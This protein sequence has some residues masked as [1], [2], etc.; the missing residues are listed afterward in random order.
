MSSARSNRR[1]RRS[2][3]RLGVSGSKSRTSATS[4]GRF[5]ACV[6]ALA[7]VSSRAAKSATTLIAVTVGVAAAAE[8]GRAGAGVV[9]VDVD[10]VAAARA[11]T[12]A[13]TAA[14]VDDDDEGMAAAPDG[15]GVRRP[16]AGV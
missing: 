15:A 5:C 1:A 16:A 7:P 2:S 11:I 6:G 12:A 10:P 13:T 8:T 14:A 3:R 9:G 4:R